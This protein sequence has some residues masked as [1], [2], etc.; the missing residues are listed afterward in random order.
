MRHEQLTN[1]DTKTDKQA[2][3]VLLYLDRC[4]DAI[5][6]IPAP[7]GISLKFQVV[8]VGAQPKKVVAKAETMHNGLRKT[9]DAA[10]AAAERASRKVDECASSVSST[11]RPT[12]TSARL[13]SGLSAKSAKR[14][15]AAAK[16]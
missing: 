8:P 3:D 13:L 1:M 14:S 15:S 5:K 10:D 16:R 9:L 6:K 12:S 2:A 11:T 7:E 4:A